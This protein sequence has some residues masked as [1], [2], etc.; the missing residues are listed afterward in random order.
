M[1]LPENPQQSPPSRDVALAALSEALVKV[2]QADERLARADRRAIG[3]EQGAA[4]QSSPQQTGTAVQRTRLSLG[5]LVL[6]SLIGPLAIVV[7]GAATFAWPS[8]QGQA[9]RLTVARWVQEGLST[10][11]SVW[12]ERLERLARP[13][14][15]DLEMTDAGRQQPSSEAQTPPPQ[16]VAPITAPMSPQLTKRLQTITRELA[17]VQQAIEQLRASQT[18]FVHDN[19]GLAERVKETQ[20][21]MARQTGGLAN[22]L[23]QTRSEIGRG[24]ADTA[25]QLKASQ[26][27]MAGISQQL[28]AVQEQMTH[29]GAT[30]QQPRPSIGISRRKSGPTPASRQVKLRP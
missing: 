7:I 20:E 21:Q 6:W 30:E 15:S 2:G 1:S 27:Q 11:S 25:A 18:Q 8:P 24:S 28:K 4:R 9:V 16:V 19:A 29:L 14:P 12:L 3:L 10:P 26:E 22:D 5:A 13:A 17:E 23:K